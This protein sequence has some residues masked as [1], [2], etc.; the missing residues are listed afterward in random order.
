MVLSPA[1]AAASSQMEVTEISVFHAL[2]CE[3][4]FTTISLGGSHYESLELDRLKEIP[5]FGGRTFRVERTPSRNG[6]PIR[7]EK[8]VKGSA[9]CSLL[10]LF[11]LGVSR[12]RS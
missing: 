1:G 8:T 7:P 3:K 12:G 10:W 2:R 11:V 6:P 5:R 4:N 9:D